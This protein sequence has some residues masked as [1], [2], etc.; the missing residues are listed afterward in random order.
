MIQ[1]SPTAIQEIKRMQHSRQQ[2]NTSLRLT[3]KQGGCAGQYYHWELWSSAPLEGDIIVENPE[4][5]LIIDESSQSYLHNLRIDYAEDLMGGGF[6]FH[7]AQATSTC[8]CGLSFQ[9]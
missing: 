9:T 2:M 8:R 7:N 4:I 6:R 1:L 5:D 3:V